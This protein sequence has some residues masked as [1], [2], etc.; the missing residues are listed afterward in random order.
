MP[1]MTVKPSRPLGVRRWHVHCP[2]CPYVSLP[3]TCSGHAGD[4]ARRHAESHRCPACRAGVAAIP[5][6]SAPG[7]MVYL[8]CWTC[9]GQGWV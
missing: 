8:P 5:N 4:G 2:V 3:L 9:R 1:R 7:D 6:P